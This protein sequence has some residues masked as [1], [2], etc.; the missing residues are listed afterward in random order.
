MRLKET[1]EQFPPVRGFSLPR[2]PARIV[3]Q[4]AGL[5]LRRKK[6]STGIDNSENEEAPHGGERGFLGSMGGTNDGLGA[7]SRYSLYAFYRLSVSGV[8]SHK[9]ALKPKDYYDGKDLSQVS[10]SLRTWSWAMP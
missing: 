5:I 4:K 10:T 7:P 8:L 6:G 1:S 9:P 3:N 2:S